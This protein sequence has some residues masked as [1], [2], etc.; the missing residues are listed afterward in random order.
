MPRIVSVPLS[1]EQRERLIFL[2][3][4]NIGVK[5]T[6]PNYSL[7]SEGK[8]CAEVATLPTLFQKPSGYNA[9][10]GNCMS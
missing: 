3:H 1:L 7:L 6:C 9:D 2:Q 10:V 5:A 4:E 8:K